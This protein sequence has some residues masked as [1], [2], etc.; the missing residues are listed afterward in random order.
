MTPK[1]IKTLVKTLRKLGVTRYEA[2]GVVFELGP[3]PETVQAPVTTSKDSEDDSKIPH[4]I[5]DL[6]SVMKLS[7]EDLVDRLFP[8]TEEDTEQ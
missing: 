7:N 2:N 3:E 1:E 6:T 8:D 5:L 4:K